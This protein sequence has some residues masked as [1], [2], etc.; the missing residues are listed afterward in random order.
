[1]CLHIY[2]SANDRFEDYQIVTFIDSSAR[3]AG[4]WFFEDDSW[5]RPAQDCNDYYGIGLVFQKVICERGKFRSQSHKTSCWVRW[6][7]YI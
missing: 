3:A 7:T 4:N 6:F 2:K 5:I 1:M